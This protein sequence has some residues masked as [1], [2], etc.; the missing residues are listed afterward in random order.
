MP[1]VVLF[2]WDFHSNC[3][4]AA[5]QLRR[6]HT[7]AHLHPTSSWFHRNQDHLV[8]ILN[9]ESWTWA[10][11]GSFLPVGSC[12]ADNVRSAIK[13]NG[14]WSQTHPCPR[15]LLPNISSFFIS[16]PFLGWFWRKL[17]LLLFFN[18]ENY[19]Y[20]IIFP[21]TE[22][23]ILICLGLNTGK[24]IILCG[25]AAVF[26]YFYCLWGVKSCPGKLW[27]SHPWKWPWPG[28]KKLG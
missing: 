19:F 18:A 6:A 11:N 3:T 14:A 23:L 27:M 20:F 16:H 28:W 13:L 1:A 5:T 25:F 26:P 21:L 4:A 2:S 24:W 10:W 17:D 15:Q 22:Y 8:G 12:G 7:W 9:T